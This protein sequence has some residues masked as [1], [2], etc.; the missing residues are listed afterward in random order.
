MGEAVPG[1][2]LEDML[3]ARAA[4]LQVSG[5]TMVQ[6]VFP[7]A[8]ELQPLPLPASTALSPGL[9]LLQGSRLC[10][11]FWGQP[12]QATAQ[13]AVGLVAAAPS[14][15]PAPLYHVPGHAELLMK[16][17]RALVSCN[18]G[19]ASGCTSALRCLELS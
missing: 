4:G 5:L 17:T 11:V 15:H 14:W 7:A 12:F 8:Q 16:A 9:P 2:A 18:L 19:L 6:F 10:W 13:R 3:L 1:A